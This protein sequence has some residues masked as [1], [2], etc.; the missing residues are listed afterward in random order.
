M[1]L[2]LFHTHEFSR[3]TVA[4]FGPR[5]D[6]RLTGYADAG[7]LSDPHRAHSQTGYVFTVG[8]TAISWRSTKQM[9]VATSL[10]HV[11]ILALHKASR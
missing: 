7:Y 1:D 5:V 10:N 9:L 3:G 8:D 6:S 2:G 4:L 11:E